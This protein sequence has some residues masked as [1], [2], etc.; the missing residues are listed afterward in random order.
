MN[1][2]TIA[3]VLLVITI[4]GALFI[5]EVPYEN[6]YA[7]QMGDKVEISYTVTDAS[8]KDLPDEATEST[9]LVIG[10]DTKPQ[11]FEAQLVGMK[12]KDTKQIEIT[13]PADYYNA[14]LQNQTRLYTVTVIDIEKCSGSLEACGAT[15]EYNRQNP[16]EETAE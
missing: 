5:L 16:S 4:V 7:A 14:E 11:E 8:G 13:Y 3:M 12:R 6:N 2:F 10:S 9:S 1:K 15:A